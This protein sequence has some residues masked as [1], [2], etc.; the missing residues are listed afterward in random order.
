M[1]VCSYDITRKSLKVMF[2]PRLHPSERRRVVS[3]AD[4]LESGSMDLKDIFYRDAWDGYL[5]RPAGALFDNLSYET[6]YQDFYSVENP[7]WANI[8][9]GPFNFEL[10]RKIVYASDGGATERI[11]T[12]ARDIIPQS[13]AI[14]RCQ[15]LTSMRRACA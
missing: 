9:N 2:L 15:R 4:E 13:P 11:M 7:V 10:D 8:R 5:H 14:D 12:G 3:S 1:D 6:F